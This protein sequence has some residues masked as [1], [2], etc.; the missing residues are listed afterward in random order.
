MMNLNVYKIVNKQ[1]KVMEVV[2]GDNHFSKDD[3]GFQITYKGEIVRYYVG[4]M[5]YE[6][7]SFGHNVYKLFLK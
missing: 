3:V 1:N 4:D 5:K 7:L 2:Y 6:G